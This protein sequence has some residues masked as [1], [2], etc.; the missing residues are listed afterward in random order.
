MQEDSAKLKVGKIYSYC[1]LWDFCTLRLQVSVMKHIKSIFM[2]N[3]Q[4]DQGL[5][6]W[7]CM[8]ISTSPTTIC[9]KAYS[10]PHWIVS[11]PSQLTVMWKCVSAL[12]FLFLCVLCLSLLPVPH[13]V[14]FYSFVVSFEFRNVNPLNFFFFLNNLTILG[15]LHFLNFRIR[16]LIS[17]K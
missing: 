7:C 2:H 17:A 12:C 14:E 6:S 11:V 1:L 3:V 9:W 4:I 16:L 5:F 8:W 15:H 13:S 10:L